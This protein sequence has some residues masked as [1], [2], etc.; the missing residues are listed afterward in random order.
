M[1]KILVA[2]IAVS[3][4]CLLLLSNTASAN[5]DELFGYNSRWSLDLSTRVTRN[6]DTRH[7]DFMHVIG[8]DLHKVFSNST[9][10][11]G[12][13]TFQPYIVKLNNV[14]NPNFIFDDGNDTQLTWR[15]TNFNY[16][17]LSQG[18][19][20]IR[21]GHFEIP[22]GLEYQIDTNGTLRQL[23]F[24][25][26]GIKADWGF[27]VNGITP[28]Y[29]YEVALTRG[30]G[31]EIT[32]K[33]DPYIFSGRFGTPSNKNFVAG[34][35]WFTGEVLGGTGVTQR[36]RIG[37]DASYYYYQWQFMAESSIGETAD[38]AVFNG[39]VE[40]Q[41]RD[42]REKF[43]IYNQLGYQRAEVNHAVTNE[44][45]TTSYWLIGVQWLGTEDFDIS[46]QYK[47][48]IEDAPSMEID[49]ILSV[50]LRYR[51]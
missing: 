47:H 43:S 26:R 32:S 2:S 51:I 21:M 1:K 22:F 37:I 3:K 24:A 45:N 35:S 42:A 20:N 12:T 40:A 15:I 5:S 7:D 31:N 30:S 6:M 9:S 25:D 44:T 46:A 34:V 33:G 50:Q 36:E 16:T 27:S 23:T 17:A 19:F 14:N 8:V 29:E 39:F 41:W 48:K 10:D 11:I 18:K 49:P 4:L 13:L 28:N 38:N